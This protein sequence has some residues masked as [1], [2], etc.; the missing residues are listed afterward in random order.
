MLECPV[1][2]VLMDPKRDSCMLQ[3]RVCETRTI[4]G[5]KA[6]FT[7]DMVVS[8][9]EHF[10]DLAVD[11]VVAVKVFEDGSWRANP[12][13]TCT[14]WLPEF[15]KDMVETLHEYFDFYAVDGVVTIEVSNRGLWLPNP[16]A[17]R[18][19]LGLARFPHDRCH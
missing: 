7:K 12:D 3:K 6:A 8:L 17:G 4:V 14:Q 18:Q 13:H 10:D 15:T 9:N 1:L 11:G 2:G 16:M 19:F 5:A